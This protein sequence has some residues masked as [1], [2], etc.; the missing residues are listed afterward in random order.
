MAKTFTYYDVED[1]E[2]H[3]TPEDNELLDAVVLFVFDDYFKQI[4]NK[5]DIESYGIVKQGIRKFID[6]NELLNFLVED[7]ESDLRDYF[8]VDARESEKH[9]Y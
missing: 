4:K 2:I 6:Y 8:E 1:N 3:Y 9:K 7:Y 5:G